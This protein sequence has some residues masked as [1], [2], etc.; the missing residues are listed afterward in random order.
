MFFPLPKVREKGSSDPDFQ[1]LDLV[2]NTPKTWFGF[3]Y[4]RLA[5]S[6]KSYILQWRDAYG[7]KEAWSANRWI[8]LCLAYEKETGF[9]KVV[10][11]LQVSYGKAEKKNEH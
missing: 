1:L 4:P 8:H 9:L 11:V 3:G 10:K 5:G 6:Y 2:I 7:A